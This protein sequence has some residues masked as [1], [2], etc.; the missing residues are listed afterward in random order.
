MGGASWTGFTHTDYTIQ[1]WLKQPERWDVELDEGARNW[2]GLT[3]LTAAV[4]AGARNH[5]GPAT[6]PEYDREKD[7]IILFLQWCQDD[8]RYIAIDSFCA[9]TGDGVGAFTTHDNKIET[10]GIPQYQGWAVADFEAEIRAL[11]AHPEL[12]ASLSSH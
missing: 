2:L 3:L 5:A 4:P 9:I 6:T 8:P 12:G 10:S 1:H 11:L 7:D